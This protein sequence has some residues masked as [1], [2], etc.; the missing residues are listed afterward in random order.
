MK[1]AVQTLLAARRRRVTATLVVLAGIA[2]LTSRAVAFWPTNTKASAGSPFS[3]THERITELAIKAFVFDRFGVTKTTRSQRDAIREI[4]IANVAVDDDQFHA[5]PHFDGER[6]PEGQDRLLTLFDEIVS[7]PTDPQVRQYL[8]SALHSL[9]DFYSHT[10]WIELGNRSPNEDLVSGAQRLTRSR[11]LEATCFPDAGALFTT[12]LTSGYY[13]GEDTRPPGSAKCNHGGV[14]DS[15]SLAGINK[16]SH[17]TVFSPHGSLHDV[18]ASVAI[19]ATKDFLR[20]IA[21]RI[22]DAK[23]RPLLGVGAEMAFVINTDPGHAISEIRGDPANAKFLEAWKDA[24][25][26][27][28]AE[29]G[30][31]FRDVK[32]PVP[33]HAEPQVAAAA[34]ASDTPPSRFLLTS[35]GFT[36]GDP[37]TVTSTEDP[38]VL[39][40][41]VHAIP[42]SG[43]GDCVPGDALRAS[44]QTLA[45]MNQGGEL[46]LFTD[47]RTESPETADAII[48]LARS[49]QVRVFPVLTRGNGTPGTGYLDCFRWGLSPGSSGVDEYQRVARETGGQSFELDVNEMGLMAGLSAYSAHADDVQLLSI[50]DTLVKNAPRSYSI[51]I[52]AT[53]TRV[54]VA[55]DAAAVTKLIRPNGAE[56][57][58]GDP[59][60]T[61]LTFGQGTTIVVETPETGTWT[62]QVSGEGVF[63]LQVSALSTFALESFRFVRFGGRPGHDGIFGV[64]DPTSGAAGMAHAV[65]TGD[66]ASTQFELRTKAGTVLGS[67]PLAR[68]TGVAA[69][70]YL[71]SVTVPS[72]PFRVWLKGIDASGHAFQRVLPKVITPGTV[73][74]AAVPGESGGLIAGVTTGFTFLVTNHGA[75]AEFAVAVTDERGFQPVVSPTGVTLRAGE[76]GQVMVTVTTPADAAVGIYDTLALTL[77]VAGASAPAA[78]ATLVAGPVAVSTSTSPVVTAIRPSTGSPGSTLFATIYGVHLDGASAVTFDGTGVTG[79]IAYSYPGFLGVTI[80]VGAG[81]A[82]GLRTFTVTTPAGTF[83]APGGFTIANVSPQ[84]L[85]WKRRSY[86]ADPRYSNGVETAA[87]SLIGG[88]IY[89]SHGY[90]ILDVTTALSIYDIVTNTWSHGGPAA[91]DAATPRAG[92]SGGMALGRHY[93]IGGYDSTG[94]KAAVEEFDPSTNTWRSRAS[95]PA[96]RTGVGTAS[97]NDKIYVVGG[98]VYGARASLTVNEVYDPTTDR[99]VTLRSM[100]APA[101][102]P[103]V[104]AYG[105]K[106]Y[107]FGGYDYASGRAI[108]TVQMFDPGSDSWAIGTPM[109]TP[110]RGA[111]AGI[112]NGQIA[113]IGGTGGYEEETE[114]YD[115]ASNTWTIGPRM[116]D[117]TSSVSQGVSFANNQVFAISAPRQG[118]CLQAQ[119]ADAREVASEEVRAGCASYFRYSM[120]EVLDSSADLSPQIA[121]ISPSSGV[122]GTT[123]QTTITGLNLA[124]ATSLVFDRGGVTAVPGS[125]T[126]TSLPV[127]ITIPSTASDATSFYSVNTSAGTSSFAAFPI[128]STAPEFTFHPTS[129]AAASGETVYFGAWAQRTMD[130]QWQVL[131]PG[132]SSWIDLTDTPPYSGVTNGYFYISNV[133][134]ALSG[135]QYR[136]RATNLLGSATSNAA[137]LTIKSV[138][139]D[140]PLTPG[141]TTIKAVHITELRALIN[142]LRARYSL[143]SYSYTNATI[144]AG[145][146]AVQARDFTEMRQALLGVY[147]AA[148]RT[149][150]TYATTPATSG[151]ILAAALV[152]LR[153][154]VL[155]I[156]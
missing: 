94:T 70:E 26:S 23:M 7:D 54:T 11:A 56:V 28:V 61:L 128:Y 51:P 134:T 107:V 17:N 143:G 53:I 35:F 40:A 39:K 57:H 8:G 137:T 47:T 132:A 49:K 66:A 80:S 1:S 34:A 52:E 2:L 15:L 60:V 64:A 67:L 63:A 97:L 140:D 69:N 48:A 102:E 46:F 10:N 142:G 3:Y 84:A 79:S 139:T 135:S 106:V 4:Q 122:P 55:L 131:A 21:D 92:T 101:A 91:P 156:R 14:T 74:V 24:T 153:A 32:A 127:V 124:G 133:S 45:A 81:A 25:L 65:L 31:T 115:P 117:Q 12:L 22:T 42:L 108:G 62:V 111:A 68:G 88:K 13:G 73:S 18:A 113:V 130:F 59:G 136:A 20:R 72:A 27:M 146:S 83:P 110:R 50:D 71:G 33:G 152:E 151:T 30:A 125:G 82:L 144:T 36:A 155:A 43:Y 6:L 116:L 104:V 87:V 154:A 120:I 96:P 129:Q 85:L 90:R 114:L 37:I 105:G 126:A 141:V 99:W 121:S 150:P 100:P 86:F 98:Y 5:A 58:V 95:M 9:Q 93:A 38:D 147:I 103:A 29:Y 78:V 112:I 123:V 149:P 41:R 75:D 19:D 119:R 77:Q 148:A 44:F 89:T 138:F 145:V 16:D 118:I 109:P 76:S